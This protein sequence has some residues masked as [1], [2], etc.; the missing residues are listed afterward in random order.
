[1]KKLILIVLTGIWIPALASDAEDAEAKLYEY[2]EVF[3]Q[4]D[5]EKVANVI[6]STPV[7]IGGG[8]AQMLRNLVAGK[9]LNMKTPQTRDGYQEL[10]GQDGD[11]DGPSG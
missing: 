6:Y 2:F 10:Y 11:D 8:T 9:V 5:A 7:H 3:N 1:M 4:K